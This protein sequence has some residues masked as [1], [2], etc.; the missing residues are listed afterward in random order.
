MATTIQVGRRLAELS[1]RAKLALMI[2][3]DALCLPLC[4]F[5]SVTLRLGSFE[6]A[7][8]LGLFIQI[9][10]GLATLP[11]L[12][13]AGLYR[14]VVRYIDLRVLITAGAALA[15]AVALVYATSHALNITSVP[16]SSVLVYWFIAFAYVVSSRFLARSMLRR[17]LKPTGRARVRT[18]IYGAGD[19]GAQLA[20][21]MAFSTEYRPVCFIDDRST[22]QRKTVAGLRVYAP[23]DLAEAVFRHEIDQIVVAIP[24]ASSAQKRRLIERVEGAGLPVKILPGLVELV[25]GKAAVSDIR[26]VDVADLLGRDPVPPDPALFAR[27][28]AGKVVLVTGAGG[29]IGSELCRQIL[30]QHPSTLV[31]LDHSEF[32]LYSI[33]HEL[34]SVAHGTRV[35]ACLG[36]VLDEALLRHA[37]SAHG[38]QTVYHAA[39]Y[40]H[41]PIVEHNMQQGLRNN[42]FGTLA[43]ARAAAEAGAETCVLISTDKAVRPTNV[44]GASKRIAELVMQA[45]ALR[46]GTRT[47]FSMVRFGNVLGS[48]GSVV[49]LFR[50]QIRNG[51]PITITHPDIIRYFMLIP[52]AAQ[53]VIQAGAMARG[54]E[55][56]VLD[57]GEPVRIA[58][59]A[60]SMVR[61]SG[62]TEKTAEHPRGDI[63][64]KAVGLRPGE[65]LF[66]ELLIGDDVQPSTHPRIMSARERHVEAALL[67]KMLLALRQACDADDADAMLRQL[68]NLVPEYRPAEEVNAEVAASLRSP[69][70]AS[71]RSS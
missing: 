56:F 42:V 66:E 30:S 15:A 3:A 14:A 62:L 59:L 31:L 13:I 28:I 38:V 18:A 12:G 55:V 52:E 1:P 29:S 27:N 23:D 44:M 47:V 39:A 37:M 17:S 70:P 68:R 19:A 16:R 65:K 67:D 24:S 69:S 10:L 25:D 36:S 61:L 51:G 40:K 46:S 33:D 49:P 50:R 32:A 60:R 9:A 5:L 4:A 48:S 34:Q 26:E 6:G 43:V 41:V 35:V 11:V 58:D 64:I 71:G 57:M 54:G 63:E 53:L 22:L 21:S 45:A 7:L 8:E 20:Y 2:G